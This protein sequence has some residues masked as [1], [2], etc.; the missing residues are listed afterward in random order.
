M[1]FT[2]M[3]FRKMT[4]LFISFILILLFFLQLALIQNYSKDVSSKIGEA[5]FQVSR[6]TVEK[7]L[8]GQPANQFKAFAFS[9]RISRIERE[10]MLESITNISNHINISLNDGQKDKFISINSSGKNLL[11]DIPRT[12]ITDSLDAMLN[13]LLISSLAFILIGVLI[14]NYFSKKLSKPLKELEKA[15][16]KVGQ[17]E[18]GFQIKNDIRFQ[19][20]EIK[21]AVRAFNKMSSQIDTLQKENE[22]L[23]KQA[24]HSELSEITRGLAHTI[25]NPLNTLNLAIEELSI[26]NDESTSK[27]LNS[28][29][30]KQ[31][32]RIDNWVKSMLDIMSNDKRIKEPVAIDKLLGHCINEIHLVQQ[33]QIDISLEII[34]TDN[35]NNFV[36]DANEVELKSLLNGLISN[37]IEASSNKEIPDNQAI[38]IKLVIKNNKGTI[39]ISI[40]DCGVGFS[41]EI[42]S[43]LFTPHNTN[44]TYGA[45]MGLY[46]AHRVITLKYQGD[47]VVTN[48]PELVNKKYP[49]TKIVLT[50]QDRV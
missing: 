39:E 16:H 37:A 35:A 17:G 14:A 40:L 38:K 43:K 27:K 23:L 45:G 3:T 25:R 20:I 42:K 36:I 46:L 26:S 1:A 41:Q 4:F 11:V 7:L 28:V 8:F 6:S 34:P 22:A 21:N 5:A 24:Q 47:I 48:N 33:K 29:S 12:G 9:N 15:S 31:I 30:K 49:G 13:K 19:S 44:K 50:L 2:N 32:Q 18:F 10:S